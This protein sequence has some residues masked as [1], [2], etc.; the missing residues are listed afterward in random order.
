MV[1]DI[2]DWAE[3]TDGIYRYEIASTLYYEL[4]IYILG[5]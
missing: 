4:H 5:T 1:R 3:I 2:E